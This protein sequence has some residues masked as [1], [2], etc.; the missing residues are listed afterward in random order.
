MSFVLAATPHGPQLALQRAL[1]RDCVPVAACL[2][3]S[4]DAD[5]V[6][7]A[8][9]AAL[10]RGQPRLVPF[11]EAARHG[12][13]KRIVLRTWPW[14]SDEVPLSAAAPRGGQTTAAPATTHAVLVDFVTAGRGSRG[15]QEALE[16]VS[17]TLLDAP[18][19]SLTG[20]VQ[21]VSSFRSS[22]ALA[23]DVT[24]P[25]AGASTAAL[26]LGD[27][28]LRAPPQGFLQINAQQAAALGAAVEAAAA[29]ERSDTVVDLYTGCGTWALL[30]AQRCAR[31]V[32]IDV[33]ASGI[34]AA[35]RNAASNG[36]TNAEFHVRD[37][38]EGGRAGRVLSGLLR[39]WAPDVVIVDP[40]RRGLSHSSVEALRRCAA[41]RLVYVSCNGES[42]ARDTRSLCAA[43]AGSKDSAPWRLTS[44]QPVD[45]FPNTH[46]CESVAAF[47]RAL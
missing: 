12:F 33:V 46:H 28:T 22:P 30:L 32:G 38:H 23:T 1:S 8:I 2:L 35:Q 43:A 5:D 3:Q 13:V 29:L 20:I 15:E 19:R 7:T 36:V 17:R 41:R 26:V 18:P 31:V 47:E 16:R 40:A 21:T 9:N 44:V 4:R 11:D 24:V 27:I 14:T 45:M 6:L 25:L 39:S 42:F 10:A 34:E 37:L